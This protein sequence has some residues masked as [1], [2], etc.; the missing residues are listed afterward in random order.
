MWNALK[1]WFSDFTASFPDIP[2]SRILS[3]LLAPLPS[4]SEPTVPSSTHLLHVRGDET[5]AE[6]GDRAFILSILS[7]TACSLALVGSSFIIILY[8]FF[9]SLRTFFRQ[10]VFW[11][12]LTDWCTALI[13][14]LA[15]ALRTVSPIVC[16]I[17]GPLQLYFSLS[18]LAWTG[19]IATDILIR[20]W[21]SSFSRFGEFQQPGKRSLKLVISYHFVAWILP[22]C[23]TI[24]PILQRRLQAN[25]MHCWFANTT[26]PFNYA[27][28][29]LALSTLV[30]CCVAYIVTTLLYRKKLNESGMITEIERQKFS[31]LKLQVARYLLAFAVCWIIVPV[32]DILAPFK[33]PLDVSFV[34]I[35]ILS[36]TLPLNGFLNSI[37]YGLDR[38]LLEHLKKM[39]F[40]R[41]HK[42]E[43]TR[44][45]QQRFGVIDSSDT[46]EKWEGP[47]HDDEYEDAAHSSDDEPAIPYASSLDKPSTIQFTNIV[48]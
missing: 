39:F 43:P 47:P 44:R 2:V 3:C 37:V 31:Y 27:Y 38:P 34:L 42:R 35:A 7:Y 28:V 33:P 16:D 14:I 36:F 41:L 23:F 5:V 45:V 1:W 26:D 17:L 15:A 29:I 21:G 30:Y 6:F 18:A 13:W 11:L 32:T 46:S 9:P 19:I 48:K 40:A 8:L 22:G 25:Y 12:S 10:L 4:P 20:L 24:D